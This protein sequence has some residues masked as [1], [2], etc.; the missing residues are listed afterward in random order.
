MIEIEAQR[1]RL[2]F[3]LDGFKCADQQLRES[4]N[5]EIRVLE[6]ALQRSI[7]QSVVKAYETATQRG[8]GLAEAY[9]AAIKHYLDL[10]GEQDCKTVRLRAVEIIW[11]SRV[12]KTGQFNSR[13]NGYT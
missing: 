3:L 13:L 6:R 1:D 4:I 5:E 2:V 7:E 9:L 10:T 12:L 8:E 11:K